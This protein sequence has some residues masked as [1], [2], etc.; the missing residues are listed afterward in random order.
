MSRKKF[1][2]HFKKICEG[3][4]E[5]KKKF[6][7]RVLP[8]AMDRGT[9]YDYVYFPEENKWTAWNDLAD[10][11]QRDKFP[12]GTLVQDIVVT[13]VDS[14][15]YSYIMENNIRNEIP[16]LFC[17]ATG[18]GKSAYITNVIMNR[19]EKDKFLPIEVGFS[20]QSKAQMV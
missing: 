10:A 9:I 6:S 18:T 13:T 5:G 3:Q 11:S 2:Q 12:A 17:G 19:L 8:G 20:A 15:R 4:Y 7:K 1:D 14:I 16:T